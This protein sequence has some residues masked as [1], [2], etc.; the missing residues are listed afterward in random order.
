MATLTQ[1]ERDE[2]IQELLAVV[3][4]QKAAVASAE[5]PKWETNCSFG[6]SEE[7]SARTNIQVVQDVDAIVK[8]YAFLLREAEYYDKASQAL[9]QTGTFKWQ[10]FTLNQWATDFATR[11]NKIQ[12]AATRKKLEASEAAL[13]K[14][15]SKD[16][17]DQME[18]DALTKEL[19]G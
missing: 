12:L 3:A 18:L 7:S 5:R 6:Y 19:L 4:K 11:V 10:G 13:H 14:L 8:M 2:K 17:R 15:V 16:K 9:G 1:A